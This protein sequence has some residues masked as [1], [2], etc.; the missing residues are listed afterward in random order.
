MVCFWDTTKS[1][2]KVQSL[3]DLNGFGFKGKLV[4]Q[5]RQDLRDQNLTNSHEGL[6]APVVVQRM[7]F[8]LFFTDKFEI[9][10]V[11]W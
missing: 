11:N 5:A 9:K 7:S 10:E 1:P 2:F 3:Y 8:V 6:T 4:S